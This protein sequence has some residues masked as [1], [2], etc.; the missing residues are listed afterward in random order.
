MI[1]L[2]GSQDFTASGGQNGYWYKRAGNHFYV[3]AIYNLGPSYA[4]CYLTLKDDFEGHTFLL[5]AESLAEGV[6]GAKPRFLRDDPPGHRL[7]LM[8]RIDSRDIAIAKARAA[9]RVKE[10]HERGG[11]AIAF[12]EN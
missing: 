11:E 1:S 9:E 2:N 3:P 6:D 10:S 4:Y 7:Q 5:E 12:E 8:R